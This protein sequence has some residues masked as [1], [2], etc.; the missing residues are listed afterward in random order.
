MKC[1]QGK[2]FPCLFPR[3]YLCVC[4]C[5][6]ERERERERVN[7]V[8]DGLKGVAECQI[9]NTKMFVIVQLTKE[10]NNGL[11]SEDTAI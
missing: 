1:A 7:R 11:T 9:V 4:V 3:T 2:C 5:V 8:V 10:N 6:C